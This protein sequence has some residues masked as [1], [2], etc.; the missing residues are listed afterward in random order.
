[1]VKNLITIQIQKVAS[2]FEVEYQ[3]ARVLLGLNDTPETRQA[4]APFLAVLTSVFIY[5]AGVIGLK[6]CSLIG[7]AAVTAVAIIQ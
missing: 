1:M 7:G 6:I 2:R 5:Y 4:L 3:K